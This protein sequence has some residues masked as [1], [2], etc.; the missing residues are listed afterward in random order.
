MATKQEKILKELE[1]YR[2]GWQRAVADYQNLLKQTAAKQSECAR[3]SERQI[4]EEFLPVYD[5]FKK[6]FFSAESGKDNAWK[7]GVAFI[8]KQFWSVLQSHGIKEIET[9]GKQFDPQKHEAL[10][11]EKKSEY[12]DDIITKEL[13]AGY[14]HH[15]KVIKPAKVVVNSSED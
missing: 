10:S 15:E 9:V 5:N 3:I 2:S 12:E 7:Q 1:E 14:T 6:A 8:M 4:L 13:E 11:R